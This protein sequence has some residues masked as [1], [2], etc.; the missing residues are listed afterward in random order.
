M[1]FN[2]F[3]PAGLALL[4][5][6]PTL[7]PASFAAVRGDWEQNLLD[8]ARNLV[9][10]LGARLIEHVSPGGVDIA[11]ANLK[12]VPSPFPTDHP[13]ADLL[14]HKTMFQL[15]WAEAL[16]SGVSTHRLVALSAMRLA[17][18]AAPTPV[19]G[20][21]ARSMTRGLDPRTT[22]DG[23]GQRRIGQSVAQV[24]SHLG[25]FWHTQALQLGT[26]FNT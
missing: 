2:G 1:T 21:E 7:D 6:L 14:R 18:L 23:T 16:P 22:L 4:A 15:R 11:G 9:N 5:R 17:R 10:D 3:P 26:A 19:V 8:P 13:G 20:C 24:T 25:C 12:R